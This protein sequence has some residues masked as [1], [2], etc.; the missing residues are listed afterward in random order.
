LDQ[1]INC[2]FQIIIKVL[3]QGQ[4]ATEQS[5]AHPEGKSCDTTNKKLTYLGCGAS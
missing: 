5:S 4:T 3:A 1:L 2:F